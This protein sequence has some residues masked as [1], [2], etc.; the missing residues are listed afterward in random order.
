MCL[1][2]ETPGSKLKGEP[3]TGVAAVLRE[4]KGTIAAVRERIGIRATVREK[5]GVSA[6]LKVWPRKTCGGRCHS[7]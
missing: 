7:I 1:A 2:C 6:I 4:R 5:A 3:A